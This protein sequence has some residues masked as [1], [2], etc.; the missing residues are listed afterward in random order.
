MNNLDFMTIDLPEDIKRY[1]YSGYFQKA[2]NLIDIYLSRSIPEVLK[3]RL[4]YQKEII[5]RLEAEYI[6]SF[7]QAY[8]IFK[9]NLIDF[10]KEELKFLQDERYT[11]WIYIDGQLRFHKR[12]L[13]NTSK[14]HP[15]IRRRLKNGYDDSMEKYTAK[16]VREIMEEGQAQYRIQAR[17]GLKMKDSYF[18][19]MK[20]LYVHLPLPNQG[21]SMEDIEIL[22][23]NLEPREV[24]PLGYPQRTAF[25]RENLNYNLGFT[26]DY[27]YTSKVKY[28]NLD[29]NI[30]S[31]KQPNFYL[32]EELPH[33]RFTPFLRSLAK[34][35]VGQEKNPLTK[36]RK[37]Y[38]YISQNIQYSFMRNYGSIDNIPE[39]AAYNLK[40]D[41]G[42]QALLFICLCRIVG[43]PSKW[44]SGMI[45]SPYGF[46][47]HDWAEFYIEPYGWVYA[48]PSF[49]GLYLRHGEKDLWNYYFGNIDP[50]R[51][52][53]NS[54]FNY[55]FYPDKK[56]LRID[57]Y[58]NQTG[59]L[60]YDDR[61]IH[62]YEFDLI[63]EIISIKKI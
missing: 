18:K 25:F 50:F 47:P 26:L 9:E 17:S 52:V 15:S 55:N 30:V 54:E 45:T 24:S 4:E 21:R 8:K 2:R 35:I 46:S 22:K 23:Y 10:T 29:P 38:N 53:Y 59:E 63:R 49:G 28:L 13:E 7:D 36:A 44:E 5:K 6:Y 32:Q 62:P 57:P 51:L 61:P 40:G 27:A 11:D 48:D 37:I 56:H 14:V 31:E 39:Y 1:I 16:I 58:D 60:E 33:L 12:I 34:E 42:V 3:K 19:P 41:C 43:I 20:T